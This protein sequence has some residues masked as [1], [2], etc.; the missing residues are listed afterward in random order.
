VTVEATCTGTDDDGMRVEVATASSSSRDHET[1]S[2]SAVTDSAVV[3]GVNTAGVD[4]GSGC[5]RARRC[6][7]A[8]RSSLLKYI[9]FIVHCVV[10]AA[11]QSCI[12][13][14]LI[15]LP[16][17]GREL[18]ASHHAAALLLTLFGAFDMAGRFVFGF[19]FDIPAVRRR[20]SLMF[21]AVAA[22]FGCG[23]ALVAAVNDYVGLAVCICVI[24]ALEGGTHS[25]RASSVTELL[26]PSQMAIGVGFVMF[27]QG[28]GNFYGPLL[29]GSIY[30][31]VDELGNSAERLKASALSTAL[32]I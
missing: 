12:Q 14:V 24:A 29:G 3:D 13:S 21:M 8:V 27:A 5:R 31:C 22:C 1:L 11:S 25:Q 32:T 20:R 4:T 15:F 17:S 18:G 30:S 10:V 23:A 19:L 2:H 16:A 7:C 26:E 9:P 6:L 28:V